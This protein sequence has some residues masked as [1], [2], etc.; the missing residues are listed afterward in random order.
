MP[1]PHLLTLR[2]KTRFDI[3]IISGF[4]SPASRQPSGRCRRRLAVGLQ[5]CRTPFEAGEY[6]RDYTRGAAGRIE[7]AEEDG[8]VPTLKE[9]VDGFLAQRR[10]AVVGVSRSPSQAANLIYRGL[11]Q[12]DHEVFAVN[13][14][15]D[16]VEGD[17][18]YADLKSIPDGVNAVLIATTPEVAEAVVRDCAELGISRVWMHRSFGRGSVSE[19]AADFCRENGITVIAGGCPRMFLPKADIGHRCMRWVLNLTGGLPKQV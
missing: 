9:A 13:P 8:T 5:D 10:I 1:S 12:A 19:K 4:R 15:A 7:I 18:C 3:F 6:N 11:R 17:A 2:V 14:N 16:E